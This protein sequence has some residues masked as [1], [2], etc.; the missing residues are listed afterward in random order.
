MLDARSGFPFSFVNQDGRIQG[1]VN[2]TRYPMFFEANIHLERRFKFRGYLWAFRFG[3][4]NIT[5]RINPDSVNNVIGAPQFRQ[6]FGGNGRST[7][8]RVR[9]LGR[10]Q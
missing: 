10:A 2:A 7:N 5:N 4:N 8:F 3:A 9:W 6:F 1:P